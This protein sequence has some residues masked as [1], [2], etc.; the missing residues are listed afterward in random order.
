[1]MGGDVRGHDQIAVNVVGLQKMKS[2]PLPEY[3]EDFDWDCSGLVIGSMT[4]ATASGGRTL[5]KTKPLPKQESKPNLPKS[6]PK[7]KSKSKSQLQKPK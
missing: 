2:R 6:K 5:S 7:S 4:L 3:E 1:M